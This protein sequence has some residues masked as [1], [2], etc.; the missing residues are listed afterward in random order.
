MHCSVCVYD[1][2]LSVLYFY[3]MR[4]KNKVHVEHSFLMN[5]RAIR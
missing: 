1:L 5:S 2:D 4:A 3:Y